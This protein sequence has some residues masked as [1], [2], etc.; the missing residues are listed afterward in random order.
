MQ[1]LAPE[2]LSQLAF[3]AEQLSTLRSLGECRGRQTLY[4]RQRPQVLEA[5]RTAATIE[6]TDASNRLEGITVPEPRIKDL[7]LRNT[8]PR[9]RSEQESAGYRDALELIHEVRKDMPVTV[10]VVRQLHARVYSHL[11]EDVGHWKTVDNDIVERA[12]DGAIIRVRFHAVPA[13][14]T[15]QAMDNLVDRYALAEQERQ[16]PLVLIPLVVLD[17]LCIHPFRDGNGRVA[18]LLTLLLLYHFDYEVGRYI[19]LERIFEKSK[20]SYYDTLEASSR[21]WHEGEHDVNPWLNYFWGV[22]QRAYNEFE[23]RVG[24]IGTGR[25]SKSQQVRD[26]VARKLGSFAISDLERDCPGVSKETIRNVLQEMR[27]E[28]LLEMRGRGRG[29]RW[30]QVGGGR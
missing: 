19:S 5:L 22:L 23:E 25:G 10:N 1:S 2:F 13:V 24:H 21:G 8:Q 30:R 17:F 7:V 20:D 27:A 28:G 18:R 6:S 16:E 4:E 12:P 3:S 29:A 14:A 26:A 15:P 9:N 11:A